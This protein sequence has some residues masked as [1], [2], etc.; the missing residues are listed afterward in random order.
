MVYRESEQQRYMEFLCVYVE[1]LVLLT[2][3]PPSVLFNLP[4]A[5]SCDMVFIVII[6]IIIIIFAAVLIFD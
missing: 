6:I 1:R 3:P 4:R 2:P 5:K